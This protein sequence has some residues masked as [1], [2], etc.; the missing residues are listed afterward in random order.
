MKHLPLFLPL[1]FAIAILTQCKEPIIETEIPSIIENPTPVEPSDTIS[2]TPSEKEEE[3]EEPKQE[4]PI[5][6]EASKILRYAYSELNEADRKIYDFMLDQI[7]ACNIVDDPTDII[8]KHLYLDFK[9]N[10]FQGITSD[11]V[12]NIAGKIYRDCPEIFYISNY[13]P[14]ESK[15]PDLGQ[16]YLRVLKTYTPELYRSQLEQINQ[17]VDA[18]LEKVPAGAD[19]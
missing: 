15:N 6:P 14:R 17:K 2:P 8:N 4:D 7:L 3:K 18:L 9:A 11:K 19:D 16:F 10:G 1:A 5:T 12:M 13:I